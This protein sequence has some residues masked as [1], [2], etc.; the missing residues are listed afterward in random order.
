MNITPEEQ[1]LL[2]KIHQSDY[3]MLDE[4]DRLSKECDFAYFL[5]YGGLLGAVRHKDFIPWDDDVDVIVFPKDYEKIKTACKHLNPRFKYIDPEDFGKKYNDM[6]PRIIDTE[7]KVLNDS[8]IINEFYGIDFRSYAGLDLFCISN[9][10]NGIKG[11]I[12]RHYLM[13]LY[14][15]AGA[16]RC[17]EISK[18]K[19]GIW[20][21]I[22]RMCETIGKLI[23]AP[24]IR[25][26]CM[27]AIRKYENEKTDYAVVSNA[28]KADLGFL[29]KSSVFE[30]TTTI[31]MKPPHEY[32]A[33]LDYDTYLTA[34]YGD[35]MKLPKE[36][37][38]KPHF[39]NKY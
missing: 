19:S 25:K 8:N 24:T 5:A 10:P 38:Q 28:D 1:E 12:Y 33:P 7:C 20:L 27:K 3:A 4:F 11:W 18:I 32:V 37:D 31:K 14:A 23:P 2:D 22:R 30:K 21:V 29:I 34:M 26:K 17:R 13:F 15:L 39:I 35:Y 36:E 6:V 16:H 9:V